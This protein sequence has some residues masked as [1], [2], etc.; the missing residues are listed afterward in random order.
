M[1][2]YYRMV[3]H[4][5]SRS[6]HH[7]IAVM[8][9]EHLQDEN[10]EKWRKLFLHHQQ[11]YLEGA[12]APDTVF[13][14]FRNHVLHVREDNWGGAP[15]GAAEWYRRT[16]RALKQNDWKHAA[17]C[18]GVMSHYVCDPVQPFHTGQTEEETTIHRAV[19]W[20][21][22]KAFPDLYQILE[23]EIGYP[24]IGVGD[25]DEWLEELVCE[26]AAEANQYYET[27][28]DHY[29]FEVGHKRPEAGLDQELKDIVAGLL[30]YAT[31]LLARVLDRAF[32]EAEAAPPNT[33]LVLDTLFAAVNTPIRKLLKAL[34]DDR[35]RDLVEAQYKEYRKTGKVRNTLGEDDK[36]VRALHAEE[37]L[38]VS[39]AALDC[40][41][42]RETGTEHGEGA[43]PRKLV[44]GKP[45]AEDAGG[46]SVD[47][48]LGLA[49]QTDDEL[50]TDETVDAEIDDIEI[51]EAAED[52]EGEEEA[53]AAGTALVEVDDDGEVEVY[54]DLDEEDEASDEEIEEDDFELDADEDD[55][56]E[57]ADAYGAPVERSVEAEL[58]AERDAARAGIRGPS[59]MRRERIR[60]RREDLV[61]DAPSIGPKTASR[62]LV[63]GVK[64]VA[65]LLDLAP[66][67]AAKKIK[68]SHINAQ[69]IRDWQ[70][71]AL[72]ACTVPGITGTIAQMLVGAGVYAPEDLLDA[73]SEFLHEAI[74]DFCDSTEGRRL[75]RDNEPPDRDQVEEWIDAAVSAIEDRDAA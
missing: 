60:L 2:V 42:P 35:D 74:L 66:H 29:N 51:E 37:V 5:V 41:W 72:L 13:K 3:L 16:V 45:R 68:A 23:T 17:Y 48:L 38:G 27:V 49:E 1:S 54:E 19:E 43:A 32:E 71:Q 7:R 21:F 61:A 73:D 65:D 69:V 62:L 14:D 30:G 20:S 4:S 39:L 12:K 10:A 44:K 9:L 33:S 6:N 56:A 64:T 26:G 75:L 55:D 47:E 18:A 46:Q 8:A 34:E 28:I 70:S 53:D 57:L 24:D 58:D 50:E 11:A 67:E 63:V 36:V 52:D 15:Q 40:E 22:S 59:E 31:V 25:G